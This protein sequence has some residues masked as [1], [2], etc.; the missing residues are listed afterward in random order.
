MQRGDPICLAQSREENMCWD[1]KVLGLNPTPI[2]SQPVGAIYLISLHC[3]LSVTW[4][5]RSRFLILW[6]HW[7]DGVRV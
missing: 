6:H 5:M 4:K 7:E 2:T 1:L 3:S